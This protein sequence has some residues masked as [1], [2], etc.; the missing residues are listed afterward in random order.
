MDRPEQ[1][2]DSVA[3]QLEDLNRVIEQTNENVEKWGAGK[4]RDATI[5]FYSRSSKSKGPCMGNVNGQ[6]LR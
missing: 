3:N 5:T 1:N 6:T 4:F 2:R